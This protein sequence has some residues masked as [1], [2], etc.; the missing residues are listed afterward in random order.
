MHGSVSAG[1]WILA[2]LG[3]V[4][5]PLAVLFIPAG[6]PGLGFWWDL[7]MGLGFAGLA[8]IGV[9]FWLTARF[10]RASA[11]FGID[12]L[13][14]FHRWMAVGGLF[15][16]L[17]HFA[18]LR[19]TAEEALRPV[20]PPDAPWHMTA[21]RVS[22]LLLI[23]LVV[24][25][26]W[27]KRFR[28]DYDWWRIAHAAMAVVAVLLA[29]WHVAATGY[30]TGTTFKRWTWIVYISAWAGLVVYIRAIRPWRLLG[31]PWRSRTLR[32]SAAGRG[33]SRWNP[34]VTRA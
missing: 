9:Q 2:Y 10:K 26:L 23:A 20:M 25:S 30:Y 8:A 19:V 18:V 17:A 14:Y 31:R 7:S 21:G 16:I 11:P 27:R 6:A 4:A 33:R 32:R 3:A 1:I 5:L 22:L 29:V 24:S 34:M 28:L 15:L 12:I 13:Y